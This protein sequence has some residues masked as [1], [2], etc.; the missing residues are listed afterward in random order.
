MPNAIKNYLRMEY[1]YAA[2]TKAI[3]NAP[4]FFVK[5]YVRY[6]EFQNAP[7]ILES[8]GMHTNF[9]KA[10]AIA[11]IEDVEIKNELFAQVQPAFAELQKELA[12]QGAAEGLAVQSLRLKKPSPKNAFLSRWTQLKRGIAQKIPHWHLLPHS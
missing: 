1:V 9:G 7:A 2:Y 5:K 3:D 11:K 6:S 12:G 8:Y 4:Y 10:C